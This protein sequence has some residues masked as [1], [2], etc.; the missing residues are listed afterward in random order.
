MG[1]WKRP[2][3]D[4]KYCIR[5]TVDPRLFW[6]DG[7][8][9]WVEDGITVFTERHKVSYPLPANGQWE[10]CNN[11]KEGAIEERKSELM[12]KVA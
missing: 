9:D 6:N 2:L 5:S 8:R 7:W 11:L 3:L 12:Q 4:G 10:N 1:N